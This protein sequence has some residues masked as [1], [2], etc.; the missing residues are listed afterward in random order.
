MMAH[1][2]V[3]RGPKTCGQC[4]RSGGTQFCGRCK[5]QCYCNA[6]CAKLRRYSTANREHIMS[7]FSRP[8]NWPPRAGQRAH[9]REHKLIC[10]PYERSGSGFSLGSK[11]R[12]VSCV[13]GVKLYGSE[14]AAL[15]EGA[16]RWR[17]RHGARVGLRNEGNT[18]YMSSVVQALTYSPLAHYLL[19]MK[20]VSNAPTS[21][22]FN[23]MAELADHVR[24][25][26]IMNEAL[27]ASDAAA[28]ALRGG[29]GVTAATTTDASIRALLRCSRHAGRMEDAHECLTYVLARLL[30]ACGVGY[31]GP[32]DDAWEK[33]T[34][35]YDV[36]GL[37]LDQAVVCGECGHASTSA[38]SEMALCLNATLGLSEAELAQATTVDRSLER[39][40]LAAEYLRQGVDDHNRP[41][42]R[43]RSRAMP[44]TSVEA[45]LRLFFAPEHIDDY[46]CERCKAR[47]ACE[48]RAGLSRLPRSLA[49]YIDRV[50]AFGAL[51]G[52]LN[53]VVA[54][55]RSLDLTPFLAKPIP[56][57]TY[58]LYAIV[59]H[60]D[61]SGSTFFGHYVCYVRDANDQ[62]WLLDDESATRLAWHQVMNI[63]P[64][65]LFY[66]K[67]PPDGAAVYDDDDD[68]RDE[69]GDDGDDDETA[70][71]VADDDR[72]GDDEKAEERVR[73]TDFYEAD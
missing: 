25:V 1:S 7:A 14:F 56:D 49:L 50:P 18:C 37:Q 19:E 63:N 42:H 17:S 55:D 46:A 43:A 47:S 21:A 65:L 28:L 20:A 60:L 64:Y 66:S 13:A 16:A 32:Q 8:L 22:G 24:K 59:T 33:T 69:R 61:F 15:S 52:K 34:L 39:R 31:D 53:R 27:A 3:E 71:A 70:P 58:H 67:T 68:R 35:V 10:R 23:L 12:A 51:F 72:D 4:G 62:W 44:P 45:L 41:P 38:L 9:W 54:F 29:S 73:Q 48:K 40:L 11:A 5:T 2:R 6:K 36:F 30:E 57:T 26:W